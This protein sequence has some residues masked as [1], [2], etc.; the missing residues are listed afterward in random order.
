VD[1]LAFGVVVEVVKREVRGHDIDG[2]VDVRLAEP[3]L[4]EL[5][6]LVPLF[7]GFPNR[8]FE[9]SFADV[10]ADDVGG[11]RCQRECDRAGSGAEIEHA[12]LG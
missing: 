8:L 6:G 2:A 4:T 5:D 1:S 10:A 3:T 7:V 12:V 9:H 11:R